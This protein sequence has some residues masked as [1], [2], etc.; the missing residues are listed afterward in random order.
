[1][2]SG[3][4][5]GMHALE[6]RGKWLI[7]PEKYLCTDPASQLPCLTLSSLRARAGS[8]LLPTA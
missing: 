7:L 2:G 5:M 4:E 8:P 3:L 6:P 1:M